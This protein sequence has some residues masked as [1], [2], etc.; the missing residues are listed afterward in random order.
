MQEKSNESQETSARPETDYYVEECKVFC[1]V[2][3]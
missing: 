1:F 3:S 2:K